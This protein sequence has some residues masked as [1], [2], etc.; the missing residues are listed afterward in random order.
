[1]ANYGGFN[2]TG[3][4][5]VNLKNT[6]AIRFASPS[7]LAVDVAGTVAVPSDDEGARAW[8]FPAKSGTFPIAGTFTVNMPSIAALSTSGTNVVI[9]GI[10]SEDGLICSVQ[11]MGT[12]LSLQGMA[13][14]GF[15]FLAGS[16]AGNGGAYLTFVNPTTTAT[17]IQ[18]YVV[19]YAAVR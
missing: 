6:A 14:Q 8:T 16:Q 12:T 17:A 9:S 7:G 3:F 15:A 10:R 5:G 19:A 11:N 18:N 13:A 2:F 1:M 4:S